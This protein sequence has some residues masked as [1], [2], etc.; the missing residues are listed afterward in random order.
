[1]PVRPIRLLW[2][3]LA[4]GVA[5]WAWTAWASEEVRIHRRL[6]ALVGAIE[7]S[8]GEG[9]LVGA[10]KANKLASLFAQPFSVEVIPEGLSLDDR[11]R[12]QQVVWSYRSGRRRIGL[13][14]RGRETTL[15][16]GARAA[17]T[18]A[19]AVVSGE[20]GEREGFRVR[21]SWVREDGDWRIRRL[22]VLERVDP[23]LF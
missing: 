14:F 6:A 2:L 13:D 5:V 8:P 16:E 21:F 4:V 17:E 22:E 23:G 10:A 15:G 9:D 7:R 3:A 19:T 20:P 18:T 12:L 1:M 11:G